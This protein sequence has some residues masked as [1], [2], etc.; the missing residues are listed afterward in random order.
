MRNRTT[1][2]NC[3]GETF[4]FNYQLNEDGCLTV[5]DFSPNTVRFVDIPAEIDSV[6][7]SR[8]ASWSFN[9]FCRLYA[10]KIPDTV[11]SIR[12][13]AFAHCS[14]LKEVVLPSGLRALGNN[15]FLCC[16]SLEKI[17]LPSNVKRINANTFFGCVKLA[18]IEGSDNIKAI[19]TKAFHGCVSL[20]KISLSKAIRIGEESFAKCENLLTCD[21]PENAKYAINAFDGTPLQNKMRRGEVLWTKKSLRRC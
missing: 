9:H 19:E 15:A 5:S 10:V 20:R 7:V 14:A 8:I 21:F 4:S 2:T 6:P 18:E 3:F 16:R 11:D 13:Y 1:I 12:N 17:N